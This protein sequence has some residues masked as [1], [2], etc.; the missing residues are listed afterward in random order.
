MN[1]LCHFYFH[2]YYCLVYIFTWKVAIY[3]YRFILFDFSVL[4]TKREKLNG[5]EDMAGMGMGPPVSE[6][7]VDAVDIPESQVGLGLFLQ[8]FR[9]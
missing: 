1:F 2:I 4:P 7:L 5:T 9:N 8:V 6:T 3:S